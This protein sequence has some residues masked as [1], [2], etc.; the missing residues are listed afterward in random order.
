MLEGTDLVFN[1]KFLKKVRWTY[2]LTPADL[3]L[4]FCLGFEGFVRNVGGY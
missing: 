2:V 1:T 3:V 4:S